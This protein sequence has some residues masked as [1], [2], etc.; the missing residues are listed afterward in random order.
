MAFP[1]VAGFV[2]TR[3]T[4]VL[5]ASPE[6]SYG[7]WLV[8]VAQGQPTKQF[9]V[10]GMCTSV[11]ARIGH[12]IPDENQQPVGKSR[13]PLYTQKQPKPGRLAQLVRAPSSHGGSH[14]F[15]SSVAH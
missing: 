11:R 13:H 14:W 1:F 2:R 8:Y 15:E 7:H 5:P 4:P 3:F 12:Q 10:L 6:A 9:A